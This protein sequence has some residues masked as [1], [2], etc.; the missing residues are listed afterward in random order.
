[1]D[2]SV[3]VPTHNRRS[4]LPVAIDSILSQQG[5]S[6]EVIVVNDGSTDGTG[7]WL[8][9]LSAQDQRIKVVHHERSRRMSAARNAGIA[10]AAAPW[11]AFCDDDDL[12]APSKLARQMDALRL[13]SARWACTGAVAVNDKL[14]IIGHHHVKG[15]QI[16]SDLLNTNV[17][18][19]G[20]SS[21]I[22]DTALLKELGG[23]D[24]ALNA[25]EDWELWIRLAQHSPLAA[26][27]HPL[28]AYRQATESR[29][30]AMSRQTVDVERMRQGRLAV[31]S[32]YHALAAEHGIHHCEAS[33]EGFLAKQLLRMGSGRQAAA[34][35][36]RL[37]LKRRRWRQLPRVAAALAAPRLTDRIG[38]ARAAAA[39][40]AGWRREAETWLG[41]FVSPPHLSRK[42]SC[43]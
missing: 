4:L 8:D 13:E 18:P 39:V 42:L 21:V 27:D 33:H 37:A 40:P 19:S 2:V 43:L 11:V 28:I 30:Y 29:S 26:V 41:A 14:Q 6:I 23:F 20:G 1:M 9:R 22:A 3:V 25:C 31:I 7:A 17:V 38:N 24:A 16:L 5:V 35:F 34:I 15:G 32:R 10:R 12:W 36:A